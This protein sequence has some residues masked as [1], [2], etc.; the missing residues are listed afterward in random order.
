MIIWGIQIKL[1]P[2]FLKL[3]SSNYLPLFSFENFTDLQQI[4]ETKRNYFAK[5]L[6]CYF[7]Q[8]NLTN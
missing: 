5:H 4:Y 3:R 6:L 8:Q 1:K 7:T 2:I